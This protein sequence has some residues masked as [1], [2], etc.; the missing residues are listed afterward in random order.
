V[1][2]S[3]PLME[4]EIRRLTQLGQRV[5]AEANMRWILLAA[6]LRQLGPRVTL[7]RE[8]VDGLRAQLTSGELVLRVTPG[9]DGAMVLALE[10][11]NVEPAVPASADTSESLTVSEPEPVRRS[12]WRRVL[13][14]CG[15]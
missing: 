9:E 3:V 7:T 2:M 13:A 15:W 1:P 5:E 12:W 4:K 11:R 10:A 14:W 6:V 8:D